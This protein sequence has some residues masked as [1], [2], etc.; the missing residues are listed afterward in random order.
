MTVTKKLLFVGAALFFITALIWTAMSF[1]P[2]GLGAYTRDVSEQRRG[3][4]Q[5]YDHFT[6]VNESATNATST[7]LEIA[8]AQKVQ[9]Y[10][11]RN[12]GSPAGATSTF[13]VEISP[14]GTNWYRYNKLI[15][16]VTNANSQDITRVGSAEIVGAT[17]TEMYAV[18]VVNDTF[19][20]IR[21]VAELAATSTDIDNTCE[22]SVRE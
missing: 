2:G 9:V 16:N 8:H 21:C 7:A 18:D 20:S 19:R 12:D 3:E 13:Y 5:R 22:F 17:A 14:D 1:L 10:F 6:A 11:T 4:I 15:S